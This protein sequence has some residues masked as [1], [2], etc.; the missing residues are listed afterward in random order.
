MNFK[1]EIIVLKLYGYLIIYLSTI[2]IIRNESIFNYI[3]FKF[4]L[5]KFIMLQKTN[6]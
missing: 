3:K 4:K 6:F 2:Q 5:V 1:I